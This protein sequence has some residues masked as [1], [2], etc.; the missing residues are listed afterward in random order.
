MI[1][2][3][4]EIATQAK[5][6]LQNALM[7][8]ITRLLEPSG[9]AGG[10]RFNTKVKPRFKKWHLVRLSVTG[11]KYLFIQNYGFE[12]VKSNGVNMRLQQTDVVN[13][14]IES[15]NVVEFLALAIGESRADE[16]IVNLKG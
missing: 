13:S 15:S 4:R 7:H 16:V 2:S 6:K 8:N 14:A 5:N 11:P 9:K 3:E 1:M 12:G 10:I